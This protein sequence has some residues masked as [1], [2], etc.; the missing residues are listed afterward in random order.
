MATDDAERQ[1]IIEEV[2][3]MVKGLKGKSMEA[4]EL[5]E[6]TA[7]S[8]LKETGGDKNKARGIAKQKGYKF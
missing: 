5:D 8:I 7:K 2:T 6:A 1:R 3:N 4:K